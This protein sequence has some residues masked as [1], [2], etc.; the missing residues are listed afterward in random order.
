MRSNPHR[1]AAYIGIWALQRVYG[2]H[3]LMHDPDRPETACLSCGAVKL[4]G[5]MKAIIHQNHND[6]EASG[7][8]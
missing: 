4:V 1:L 5:D 8:D 3:C 6:K 2:M 7:P